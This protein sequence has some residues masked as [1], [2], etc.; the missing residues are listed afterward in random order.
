VK[1]KLSDRLKRKKNKSGTGWNRIREKNNNETARNTKI[2]N[3]N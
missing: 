2:K 3:K 1:K